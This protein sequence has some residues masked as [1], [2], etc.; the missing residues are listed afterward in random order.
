MDYIKNWILT[1][2][3][4]LSYNSCLFIT[5]NSGIGKSHRI[6]NLCKELDLFIIN[7]NSY[8]CCTSKQLDDSDELG[9]SLKSLED[10][11]LDERKRQVSPQNL[12]EEKEQREYWL[13]LILTSNSFEEI[14]NG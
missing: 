7:I 3:E 10:P 1:P 14:M 5:G 12:I 6:N 4:K 13:N 9:M 2:R 11:T 8:N